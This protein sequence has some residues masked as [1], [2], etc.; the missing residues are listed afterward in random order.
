MIS[1]KH[2]F[3]NIVESKRRLFCRHG[4]GHLTFLSLWGSLNLTPSTGGSG[5][6]RRVRESCRR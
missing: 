6:G 3:D 4:Q 2:D 1:Q 5:G